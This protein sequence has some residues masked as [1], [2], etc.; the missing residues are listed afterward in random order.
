MCEG[1][2]EFALPLV[3]QRLEQLG[4]GIGLGGADCAF[5]LGGADCAHSLET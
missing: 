1:E 2:G 5:V 3:R 4:G